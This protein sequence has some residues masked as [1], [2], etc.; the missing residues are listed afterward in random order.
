MPAA[1][2]ASAPAGREALVLPEL[3]PHRPQQMVR[4]SAVTGRVDPDRV[5]AS[6][7]EASLDPETARQSGTALHALLQHLGRIAP[8]ER[9]QVAARALEVLLPAAPDQHGGLAAR[10]ISILTRPELAHLFGPDSRAEV[11]F[12][13][14]ARKAGEPVTLAGRIDRLMATPGGVLIVDF[15]SDAE[16][17]LDHKLVKPAYLAQLGLYALAAQQLFPGQRIE[18]AILWTGL[19]SLLKLPNAALAEAARGFTIR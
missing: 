14:E 13:V 9:P 18:A 15:K 11:P 2:A 16:A 19:E 4:P 6:R 7:L 17:T 1:V 12:L 10:A 8:A 5:L 3:P